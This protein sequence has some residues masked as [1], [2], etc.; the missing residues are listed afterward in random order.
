MPAL[1]GGCLIV[2]TRA[3]LCKRFWVSER[4]GESGRSPTPRPSGQATISKAHRHQELG[5]QR[6]KRQREQQR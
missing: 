1:R 4:Y 3:W 5:Q 2:I 6:Q